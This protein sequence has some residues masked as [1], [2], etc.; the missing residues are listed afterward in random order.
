MSGSERSVAPLS[1]LKALRVQSAVGRGRSRPL[2]VEAEDGRS[3]VAKINHSDKTA[4]RLIAE[5]IAWH[6]ANLLGL[7]Q[8]G[9]ALLE[10]ARDIDSP[11]LTPEKRAELDAARGPAFGSLQLPDAVSLRRK[12]DHVLD[13]YLA[14]AIIWFDS[15]VLNH[16]RK[17]RNPNILVMGEQIW[18]I[19]NDSVLALHHRWADSQRQGA[20]A[21]C[22]DSGLTWWEP[23]TASAWNAEARP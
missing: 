10:I 9:V 6:I 21:M 14:A 3:Y 22:P 1:T 18:M 5:V 2:I 12:R 17:E 4:R 20:Y 11:E 19:D 16:D 15:L 7:P 8:P 23:C 13:P